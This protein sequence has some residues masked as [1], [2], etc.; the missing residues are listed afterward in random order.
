MSG[1]RVVPG[2]V[3]PRCAGFVLAEAMMVIAGASLLCVSL[4]GL[5]VYQARFHTRMSELSDLAAAAR[6]VTGGMASELAE[7][8]PG[9]LRATLADTLSVRYD[10]ER[11]VVC[12]TLS[13]GDL[14]L[15]VY[16]A[17]SP[18]LPSRGR[19]AAYL[20][21]YGT[22][23]TYSEGTDPTLRAT[24]AAKA[25]CLAAGAVGSGSGYRQTPDLN[26]VFARPPAPGGLIRVYG[27]LTYTLAA[28][29]GG[30]RELRRNGQQYGVTFGPG[31][32]FEYLVA[33]SIWQTS[34]PDSSSSRVSAVRLRGQMQSG[35]GA[36]DREVV[37]E[38][39]LLEY[40]G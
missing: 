30:A 14:A 29:D 12:G 33:D 37:R 5:V 24:S 15:L 16:S 35:G 1:H 21:P 3:A 26:G 40:R 8:S 10:I 18:N 31:A 28:G 7:I 25:E 22:E 17:V 23:Y 36:A 13:D 34:V 32:V 11:A 38:V 20:P 2:E 19:G 27:T 6:A 9:D 4:A 39:R